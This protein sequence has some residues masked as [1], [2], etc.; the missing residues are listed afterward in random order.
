MVESRRVV[1]RSK[2]PGVFC[3]RGGILSYFFD[4]PGRINWEDEGD[5]GGFDSKDIGI[6]NSKL[7]MLESVVSDLYKRVLVLEQQYKDSKHEKEGWIRKCEDLEKKRKEEVE[8]WSKKY[9]DLRL[10]VKE[11]NNMVRE[12]DTVEKKKCVMVF[13]VG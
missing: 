4:T 12:N 7:R 10:S 11:C 9:D 3:G 8:R 2:Q 5:Y 1:E 13:G 6:E